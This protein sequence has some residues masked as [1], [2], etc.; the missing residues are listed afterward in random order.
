MKNNLLRILSL[1]TLLIFWQIMA[2][3]VN[4]PLILPKP[5]HVIVKMFELLGQKPFWISFLYT[6]LRCICAFFMTLIVGTFL[7]II[8]GIYKDF[9]V[10]LEVP[11]SVIRSTPVVS[12]VLIAIF[13]FSSNVIPVFISVVMTLPIMITSIFTGFEQVDKKLLKMAKVF[14]FSRLQVLT[15]I[16]LPAIKTHFMGG[17]ISVFG[18]SWKV[19]A[20]GEVLSLPRNGVGT[21]LQRSQVHLESAEVIA[22]TIFYVAVSFVLGKLPAV[23]EH[24]NLC[25]LH[26]NQNQNRIR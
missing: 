13:W 3:V 16:Q 15:K 18:L 4:A 14:K 19:V 20:A 2:R 8:C 6:F 9:Y 11:L 1:L 26:R 25:H 23:F 22:I 10:F 5:E 17:V 7:G 21:I 24:L 12:F